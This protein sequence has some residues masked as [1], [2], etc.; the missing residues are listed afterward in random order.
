MFD[1][2]MILCAVLLF[3]D[4]AALGQNQSPSSDAP[5][6][7]SELT[8]QNYGRGDISCMEW[9]DNCVTCRRQQAGQEYRCSNIGIS[10]QPKNVYCLRRGDEPKSDK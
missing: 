9:S 8:I 5:Q 1:R 3:W 7:P 6:N 2:P 4:T 10:C